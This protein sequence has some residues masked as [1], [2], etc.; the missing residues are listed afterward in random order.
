MWIMSLLP[1]ILTSEPNFGV[2]STV[3]GL[4]RC[5]G[6][7]VGGW[8]RR[9]E[10][11]SLK[12]EFSSLCLNNWVGGSSFYWDG[13][14]PGQEQLEGRDDLFSQHFMKNFKNA[15]KL[16]DCMANTHIPTTQ[17]L[18]LTYYCISFCT[19]S[20]TQKSSFFNKLNLWDLRAFQVS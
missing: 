17:I 2:K 7:V 1:Y 19:S 15:E 3:D 4:K 20:H 9:K 8:N 12:K 5:V 16:T 14:P 10:R 18:Q 11:D 13:A 6:D